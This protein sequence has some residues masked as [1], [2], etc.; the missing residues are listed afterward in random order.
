MVNDRS[1]LEKSLSLLHSKK[2]APNDPDATRQLLGHTIYLIN[3]Q[4][5]PFLPGQRTPLQ[6]PLSQQT[7]QSPKLAFTITDTHLIFGLEATVE[8][9]IR[10]LSNP[11]AESLSSVKWFNKASSALPSVTALSYLEDTAA[12]AEL[13]WWMFKPG[14]EAG[15]SSVSAGLA[16]F[17]FGPQ[18]LKK[19]VNLELLPDFEAVRKYFGLSVS[20][21]ISRDDGFFFEFRNI[22]PA[23]ND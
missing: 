10:T 4:S 9:T 12:S 3:A 17:P 20:Y 22:N 15:T 8:R 18:M 11:S 1:A 16:V 19:Y 2:I 13:L 14:Q 6:D 5:L 21:G 7:Q 23:S